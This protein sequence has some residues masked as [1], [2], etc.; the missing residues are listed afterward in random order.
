MID[1]QKFIAQRTYQN[2]PPNS[3]WCW[4]ACV[5]MI[6]RWHGYEISQPRIVQQMYGS[7]VNMPA[8]DRLLT[9][10][11][12]RSWTA[13][14]GRPFKT[15][16]KVFSPMLGQSNVDNNLV[17]SDLKNDQPLICG[18]RSH[19]TVVA[20]VDYFSG[21]PPRVGQVHVVDPYPGAAAP[22]FY[23]RF[24]APDEMT[25]MNFGGQLRYLASI[26]VA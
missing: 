6:C 23:A 7:V 9:Q 10:A 3:Q 4:A 1:P 24:L 21:Q 2:Q 26:R 25:P 11:L 14:N 15:S 19:A 20:R 12:N 13:D 8:D 16:A 17:I 5:S 18:A 22:P